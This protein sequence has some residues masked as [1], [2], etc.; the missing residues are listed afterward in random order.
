M[1]WKIITSALLLIFAFPNFNLSFL[2]FIGFI[3]FFS[4]IKKKSPK[5]AF[6]ISYVCGFLFYLG[7]LYWLYHVTVIGLVVLCLYLAVYFGIFGI[8]V[9]S[10]G[11]LIASAAWII[12]EYIQAHLPIMGF[13][14]VLLGY[15]QY[16]NLPLI[17]IADFSGVYGVSF[18]VMMVNVT[19]WRLIVAVTESR[20]QRAERKI[21]ALCSLL[22]ALWCWF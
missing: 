15:S 16:K 13:G 6:L 8:V 22:S 20:E 7:T 2:A 3:P 14:W 4:V 21:Y 17:Q 11:V 9:S 12:L 1:L 19:A 10:F 5:D 18:V